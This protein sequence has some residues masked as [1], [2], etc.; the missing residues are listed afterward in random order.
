VLPSKRAQAPLIEE[1]RG[2]FALE[3]KPKTA[4]EVVMSAPSDRL[5]DPNSVSFYAGIGQ[6]AV[7]LAQVS[8]AAGALIPETSWD[9][10]GS[11]ARPADVPEE[12]S[13]KQRLDARYS[14]DP[15]ICLDRRCRVIADRGS[16]RPSVSC[17][18]S[19]PRRSLLLS[20]WAISHS[21]K[22]R[23]SRRA[24]GAKGHVA[25]DTK[26]STNGT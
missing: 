7:R 25:S 15:E 18:S 26:H 20:P 4:G 16:P 5:H 10:R 21:A 24:W 19:P 2:R 22:C 13:A 9:N 3:N 17:W 23:G 8:D 6:R 11:H 14:P 12:E 1:K